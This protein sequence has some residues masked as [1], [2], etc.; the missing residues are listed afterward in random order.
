MRNEIKSAGELL[1]N[2]RIVEGCKLPSE[3]IRMNF[4][5]TVKR[6]SGGV[7]TTG[8]VTLSPHLTEQVLDVINREL[9]NRIR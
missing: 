6:S 9:G 8:T 5:L 4:S 1:Q 7:V 2:L 3:K